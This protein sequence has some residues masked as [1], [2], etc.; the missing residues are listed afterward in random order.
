MD[1]VSGGPPN[2]HDV[3][4]RVLRRAVERGVNFID[5]ADSYGPAHNEQIIRK[6]LHPYP[7]DLAIATKGGMLRTGPKDFAARKAEPLHRCPRPSRI[8]T[9]AGRTEPVQSRNRVH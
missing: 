4:V 3:A 6:A 5:T 8:P 9:P 1:R 7:E 2:D